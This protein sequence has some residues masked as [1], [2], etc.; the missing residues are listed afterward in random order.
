MGFVMPAVRILDNVQLDANTYV[1]KIKEVEAG[2]GK[3][4]PIAIHGHGPGRRSGRRARHPHHRA[5]L[6]PA[7][8][9]GGFL[10]TRKTRR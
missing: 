4:W 5:D 9:L 8:D 7:C 1:I 10:R 6:R 2:A 3:L